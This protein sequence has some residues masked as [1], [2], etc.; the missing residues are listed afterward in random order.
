M[1][2][3][4]SGY[5]PKLCFCCATTTC[6]NNESSAERLT[7]ADTHNKRGH[8]SQH[9]YNW[10]YLTDMCGLLL[11]L[12]VGDAAGHVDRAA[13]RSVLGVLRLREDE[14]IW[15]LNSQPCGML[16]RAPFSARMKHRTSTHNELHDYN[17]KSLENATVQI[18][19]GESFSGASMST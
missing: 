4:T 6:R 1:A 16:K 8:V 18:C 11:T 3:G 5:G 7:D 17:I 15:G 9:I 13:D 10:Q 12:E 14:Q 2:S 19:K